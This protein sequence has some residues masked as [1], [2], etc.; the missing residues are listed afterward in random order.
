MYDVPYEEIVKKI[1][2]ASHKTR[3]EVEKMI[4]DQKSELGDLVSKEGAAR[5]VA[6][7]IGIKLFDKLPEKIKIKHVLAGMRNLEITGKVIYKND[8]IDFVKKDNS[9]GRVGSIVIG[10]ETG[11]IRI[12]FWN[13]LVDTLAKIKVGDIVKVN[14]AFSRENNGRVEIH[15]GNNSKIEINPPGEKI[16]TIAT[17]A[18]K[19]DN[20][21]KII[22]L[23]EN[24]NYVTIF[25]HIVNVFDIVF[26]EV[27]PKCGKRIKEDN[28]KFVCPVHGEVTPDYSYVL[29][30]IVDDGSDNIRVVLFRNLVDTLLGLD[31]S[32][33]L[34]FRDKLSEF[35][36][37]KIDLL[38]KPVKVTGRVV[39]NAMFDRL[40]LVASSVVPDPDP[41]E[42][43]K[44]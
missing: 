42:Q 34:N 28:G 20:N 23:T 31:K 39:K 3:E 5:I 17:P 13:D 21:K 24:D 14:N 8:P 1:V 15:L 9:K 6:N 44:A 10:D 12:V 16:E 36:K 7:K 2:E 43:M 4:L 38:G 29:N 11:S 18:K 26:Y 33:V 40:E 27:C 22:D 32:N 19:D 37:I 41:E 30:V 35:D 25:G